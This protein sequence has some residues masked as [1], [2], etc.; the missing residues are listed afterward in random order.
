[1]KPLFVL[2]LL[3]AVLSLAVPASAGAEAR[4]TALAAG[5]VS[6]VIFADPLLPVTADLPA[7]EDTRTLADLV[8]RMPEM[9]VPEDQRQAFEAYLAA[10]PGSP[11]APSV[12]CQLA[13]YYLSIGRFTPALEHYRTAWT[14]ARGQEA[15]HGRSVAD[16]ALAGLAELLASLGRDQEL[17]GVLEETR[18]RLLGGHAGQVRYDRAVEAYG[19][20]TAHPAAS[21]RCGLAA[22]EALG[23]ELGVEEGRLAVLRGME[24]APAG[25]SLADLKSLA[26][27]LGLEM[28]AVAL[29]QA[30]DVPVPSVVH[31]RAGHFA[32]VL[33]RQEG[34]V[35][36]SDPVFRQPRWLRLAG[37]REEAGGACLVTAD[38]V[39]EG[40]RVL[41]DAEAAGIVGRGFPNSIPDEKD[42]YVPGTG[43][44]GVANW[45]VSEPFINLWLEANTV[46][47]P[48]PN[49]QAQRLDVAYK[50][51]NSRSDSAG[52]GVGQGW[53]C[54]WLSYV[55]Y[56]SEYD[57][58]LGWFLSDLQVYVALGGLRIYDHE[59]STAEYSSQS[60]LTKY[61]GGMSPT[62]FF[63]ITFPN[64]SVAR[65]DY[66][67]NLGFGFRRAYLKRFT[68]ALD[69][70]TVWSYENTTNG[71]VRLTSLEDIQDRFNI[72]QYASPTNSLIARVIDPH[73]RTNSFQYDSSGRL[74]NIVNPAGF[75]SGFQYDGAGVVTNLLTSLGSTGFKYTTDGSTNNAVTRSLTVTMPTG[76]RHLF[77]YRDLAAQLSGSNT[78]ALLPFSY[79]AG[80]VPDTGS[81]TNTFDNTWMQARNTF[82]W[83]PRVY[84]QLS[85]AF[86]VSGSFNDLSTNDY[87]LAHLKHWLRSGSLVDRTLS[88]ERG[89]SPDG[90]REGQKL[91]YDYF[92]KA[93]TVST[94]Q[95]QP[96]TN[97]YSI[98]S[99]P[100]TRFV[101]TRLPDGT[102]SFTYREYNSAG[103]STRVIET[104]GPPG[105][106]STR[107][108]LFNYW[109]SP[110]LLWRAYDALD[111]LVVSNHWSN[112]QLVLSHNAL[113]EATRYT[114]QTNGLR[115]LTSVKAPNGLTTTNIYYAGGHTNFL[116]KTV[117]IE[118]G[119]TNS[120]A[121]TNGLLLTATSERGATV[122]NRYDI[123]QRLTNTASALGS[124]SFTYSNLL[125][126]QT[127]DAAGYTNRFGYDAYGRAVW[128][129][130]P[131]NRTNWTAYCSCGAVDAVTNALGQ[132]TAFTYDNLGRVTVTLFHD[133]R[134]VT[135]EYD[136]L[137][138]LFRTID[139]EGRA[140]T[141]FYTS[142]GL[143]LTSSNALGR[144]GYAHYDVLDRATNAVDASGLALAST[145]DI[146]GRPLS[147]THPD[148][149]VEQF[150]YAAGIAGPVAY[151]NQLS[152]IWRYA[153]DLAGRKTAE[154][155]ASLE[156]TRWAYG[157]SGEL[158]S[159]TDTRQKVTAWAYDQ[160]GRLTA[161]TN[162]SNT[163]VFRYDYDLRGLMTNRWSAA[164]G[165]TR[166]AYDAVGNLT[167]IDYNAG[168]DVALQYDALNRITNRTDAAG[169]TKYVFNG[170][171][172][173]TSED[174]PWASDTLSF[175]Y[176]TNDLPDTVTLQQPSGSWTAAYGYDTG[177]RLTSITTTAGTFGYAY[178]PGFG[179]GGV[180]GGPVRQISLPGGTRITNSFDVAG[181]LAAT[182]LMT[183]QGYVL[184]H[185]LYGYNLAG[186]A[187][188][189]VRWG[190]ASLAYA[191]DPAGRL[192]AATGLDP[193]GTLRQ[194]EQFGYAYDAAGNLTNRANGA[195]VLAYT[196]DALNQLSAASRSG[197]L[198]VAGETTDTAAAV[199]VNGQPAERYA[200]RTFAS[201]GHAVS[202]GTNT[203]TAVAEDLLARRATNTV[204]AVVPPAAA[205]FQYDL[206]GNLLA[207]GQF[208]YDYDDENQLVRVTATN[209]WKSE[210]THD[211]LGR[212]RV[213]KEFTWTGSAWSQTNEVRYVC[214]GGLVWQER[215][216]SNNPLASYSRGLSMGGGIGGLLARTLH[217]LLPST[218]AHLYYHAD[219]GGN[220]T[221]LVD[222]GQVVQGRYVYDPYGNLTAVTGPKAAENLYRWSSKETHEQSGL[223]YYGFR[224]YSPQHHRWLNADPLGEQGGLNLF[225]AF[226]NN[227]VG[228]LDA[229]GHITITLN[230]S[231]EPD[232]TDGLVPLW[233]PFR[234]AMYEYY[235]GNYAMGALNAAFILTD[236]L[237]VGYAARALRYAKY[238][239]GK[240][241]K[242]LSR[243]LHNANLPEGPLAQ[244]GQAIHHWLIEQRGKL[245]KMVKELVGE[246]W[247]NRIINNPL[248]LYPVPAVNGLHSMAVHGI[249]HHGR[250]SETSISKLR[251][252]G[253]RLWYGSPEWAKAAAVSVAGRFVPSS[254]FRTPNSGGGSGLAGSLFGGAG[255]SWFASD[256]RL[257]FGGF[258][259]M[260]SLS[261]ENVPAVS[262][263]GFEDI[264][265]VIVTP[266][267]LIWETPSPFV[268]TPVDFGSI[269]CPDCPK[270]N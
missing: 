161:K 246:K 54:S 128:A 194:H 143:L 50:Q 67:Q 157:V 53:E 24:A 172:R 61:G 123:L 183:G 129:A 185:H 168:T 253:W 267:G 249:I 93:S 32:A 150:G 176:R 82:Y 138:R 210:F 232:F 258:G 20:M 86:L 74:T 231:V 235:N 228:N 87:R 92:G 58:E 9:P 178:H 156:V 269:P 21:F 1:M 265:L 222:Q 250:Y 158:L 207:D 124:A 8:A 260:G 107:T 142:H 213:R 242:S 33:R 103:A 88:L 255:Q 83:P 252:Y 105:A 18:G 251:Q 37:L 147:V 214:V 113:G 151:T 205:S 110:T 169:T 2:T 215:D 211:S 155:N 261:G 229:L 148:G 39:P 62:F 256:S 114:Y 159:L 13:R 36:V 270:Q 104:W 234:Q 7:D 219:A 43:A 6:R 26:G 119:V 120:F 122:T 125:L 111:R 34:R 216:A 132:R 140:V 254:T 22:L 167:N 29:G 259:R 198:T 5:L 95:G 245:S 208:G 89:P 199:T 166:Y 78:N 84:D 100:L 240:N 118:L 153:Y 10:S 51:R 98:G 66:H 136:A 109:P 79:P 203:F 134:G 262:N 197:T 3:A 146:L 233:G 131:L 70:K 112:N 19:R 106:V 45:R 154:T 16:L 25:L 49:G 71:L 160:W 179:A 237:G 15:G 69:R 236:A 96:V 28:Q 189:H 64:E 164:K 126:L 184:N 75:G 268:D 163:V 193:N 57:A 217:S 97:Y 192:T 248:N 139:P 180:A 202:A 225:A 56:M 42:T 191:Y 108:N 127:V 226:D 76:G 195:L 77:M 99:S 223:V 116:E 263:D 101:A 30:D 60:K 173:L 52:F 165:N 41:P 68:D 115:L 65:Y 12:R 135:N 27:R 247:G 209:Q 171:G 188:N 144:L 266:D 44:Y 72:V 149:G 35:L 23:K 230:P 181:R 31:L 241:W 90:I 17:G 55:D 244:K 38:R 221:A 48:L 141:N 243:V 162:A 46:N 40:A 47:Y 137:G 206:V 14:E 264:G 224:F 257:S 196:V 117:I 220:V 177:N 85:S 80:E 91:W 239:D 4:S 102:S 204:T 121:Y 152:H 238:V 145:F 200:D 201:A 59:G 73:G 182:R 227:P 175:T 170:V 218:N 11:W 94:N 212:R 63:D 186:Q 130:D 190:D 187:T 133:G 81:L 174:G